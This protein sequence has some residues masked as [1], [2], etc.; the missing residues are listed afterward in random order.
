[1]LYSKLGTVVIAEMSYL[2]YMHALYILKM[3]FTYTVRKQLCKCTLSGIRN[4]VCEIPSLVCVLVFGIIII[5]IMKIIIITKLKMAKVKRTER[6][7][8]FELFFFTK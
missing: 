6:R 2:I 1:M 7:S 3:Y 8:W 5:I 4:A